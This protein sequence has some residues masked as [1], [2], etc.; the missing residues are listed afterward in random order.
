MFKLK[1]LSISIKNDKFI[2]TSLGKKGSIWSELGFSLD[3]EFHLSR[4][5][6]VNSILFNC[7]AKII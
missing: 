2:A 3:L 6:P 5:R 7:F 1:K 4:I